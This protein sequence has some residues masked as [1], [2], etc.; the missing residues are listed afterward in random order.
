VG[1]QV[2]PI[3]EICLLP[4]QFANSPIIRGPSSLN[5]QQN[6]RKLVAGG[7]GAD[8]TNFGWVIFSL[9]TIWLKLFG[10]LF[11]RQSIASC[12]KSL[13]IRQ[14]SADLL[15]LMDSKREEN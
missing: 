9:S 2:E 11:T 13:L 3:L 8:G 15:L 4:E 5:G 7:G 1:G 6:R 10:P 12:L 14:L